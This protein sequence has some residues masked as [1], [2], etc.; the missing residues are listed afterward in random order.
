M[1]YDLTIWKYVVNMH[2][3]V[4][5]IWVR[6]RG[7]ESETQKNKSKN[8]DNPS[9]KKRRFFVLLIPEIPEPTK[10]EVNIR[11]YFILGAI[12]VVKL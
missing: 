2:K 11:L 6:A 4:L 5:A 1:L 10:Y 12:A 8:Q 3:L 9:L 7:T